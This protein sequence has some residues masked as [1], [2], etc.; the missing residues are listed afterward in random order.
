MRQ[1]MGLSSAPAPPRHQ[2]QPTIIILDS[3]QGTSSKP[4]KSV[5]RKPISVERSPPRRVT[6]SQT[7]PEKLK[8]DAASKPTKKRRRLVAAYEYEELVQEEAEDAEIAAP[9]TS[10]KA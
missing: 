5:K 7:T 8:S 9:Q 10:A 6:R 2:Q 3:A 4:S 1:A